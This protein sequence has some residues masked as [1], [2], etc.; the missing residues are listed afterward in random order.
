MWPE[1]YKTNSDL[2]SIAGYFL[3]AVTKNNGCPQ[4]V[5]FDLGTENKHV[6]VLASIYCT[7]L[8]AIHNLAHD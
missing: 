2:R 1:A 5:R 6:A 7:H 4:K 8:Y 3:D